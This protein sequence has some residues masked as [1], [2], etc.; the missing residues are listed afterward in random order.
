MIDSR[1][2]FESFYLELKNVFKKHNVRIASNSN[3]NDDCFFEINGQ[4]SDYPILLTIV[5]DLEIEEVF[6][7]KW[8]RFVTETPKGKPTNI[9]TPNFRLLSD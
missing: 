8:E 5:D 2:N 7:S 1:E 6:Q 4:F 9:F 3:N